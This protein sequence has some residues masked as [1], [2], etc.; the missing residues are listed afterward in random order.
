M[1]CVYLRM[2]VFDMELGEEF[3]L[4][5]NK[6]E[7]R[8]IAQEL[9]DLIIYCQAV[10][11]PG[12]EYFYHSVP[13]HACSSIS[14]FLSCPALI[15][16]HV[17]FKRSNLSPCFLNFFNGKTFNIPELHSPFLS[18]TGHPLRWWILFSPMGKIG[19]LHFV[20]S[21]RAAQQQQICQILYIRKYFW[22]LVSILG[23]VLTYGQNS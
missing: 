7:S 16:S 21:P 20:V 9:S 18:H 14:F 23:S 19:L 15:P 22:C 8:Q 1:F 6:K 17:I 12:R 2:K 13:R 3:Y 10:K 4:P 5:Q 11:F